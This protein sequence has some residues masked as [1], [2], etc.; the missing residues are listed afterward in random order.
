MAAP[1]CDAGPV[2][3]LCDKNGSCP[4]GGTC[5]GFGYCSPLCSAPAS[6]DSGS[7]ASSDSGSD[8]SSDSAPD[9][10]VDGSG[11]SDATIV[12]SGAPDSD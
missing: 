8:A 6:S 12:D 7:D 2:D 11:P 5:G 1:P 9:A 10:I 4:L 3:I